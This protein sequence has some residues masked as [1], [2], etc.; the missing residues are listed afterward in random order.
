[1]TILNIAVFFLS[2]IAFTLSAYAQKGRVEERVTIVERVVEKDSSAFHRLNK[3]LTFQYQS[4]GVGPISYSTQGFIAGY[5]VSPNQVLQVELTSGGDRWGDNT[6]RSDGKTM[7]FYYKQFNGNSFYFK[8][9]LEYSTLDR[10]YNYGWIS[11]V[12][13]DGYSYKGSKVSASISIGNQWQWE[14]FTLG[15]DWIGIS[16]PLTH[17]VHDEKFWGTD[18]DY[19]NHRLQESKD[20]YLKN[21]FPLAFHL[22]LGVSF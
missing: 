3:K 5:H 9:G 14:N 11:N 17:E 12:A 21:G 6:S 4:G 7:G 15:C 16:V 19:A 8:T 20:N 10:Y 2:F 13:S 22:Y 1:M 18:S